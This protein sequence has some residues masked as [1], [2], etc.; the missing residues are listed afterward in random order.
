[1]KFYIISPNENNIIIFDSK[2][3]DYYRKYME[4]NEGS[5][6]WTKESIKFLQK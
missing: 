3:G 1:M 5:T 4:S 2:T 6:D